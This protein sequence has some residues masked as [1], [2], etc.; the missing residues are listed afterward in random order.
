MKKY[1]HAKKEAKESSERL[2]FYIALSICM[3][4]VGLAIWSAYASFGSSEEEKDGYFASLSSSTIPAAQQMTGVTEHETSPAKE[5]TAAPSSA[6]AVA[7]TEAES[8]AKSFVI[9]ESTLPKEEDVSREEELSSLQAVLKVADSLVYP[10]KSRSVLKQYS[11]EPVY[12]KTM[13]DYRSHPGCDFAAESGEN[14]YAMCSGTVKD[15][16]VSELYG[17]ILE[18]ES[19]GFSV[20]YCGLDAQ[21]QVDKGDTVQSGDTLGTV[22]VVPCESADDG[23]IHIEIRVGNKLI[24]PLSVINNES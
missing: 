19:D 9:Y 15:I 4:A 7:P 8:K 22:A 23:H 2:G 16:S 14:V 13:G 18:V 17:L 3:V 24:D 1:K 6:P 21:P 5:P 12:S 10:V 20:Y 11:E